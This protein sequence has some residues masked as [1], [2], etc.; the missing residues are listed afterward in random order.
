MFANDRRTVDALRVV[1]L[2]VAL[3]AA[4]A[5]LFEEGVVRLAAI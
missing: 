3:A 2:L 4:G 5:L 1:A